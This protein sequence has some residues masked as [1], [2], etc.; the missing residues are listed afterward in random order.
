MERAF[1]VIEESQEGDNRLLIHCNRGQNRS[2]TLVIAWLMHKVDG[3]DTMF[4]AYQHVKSIRPLIHPHIS[5]IKQLRNLDLE[6]NKIN[7]TPQNF[8]TVSVNSG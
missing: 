3:F 2:P 4:K 7:S 6:I 1:K 8:L 5:Y